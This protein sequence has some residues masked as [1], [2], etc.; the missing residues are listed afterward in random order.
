VAKILK[1]CELPNTILFG[2]IWVSPYLFRGFH[3]PHAV[4]PTDDVIDISDTR[5]YAKRVH[6]CFTFISGNIINKNHTH[7][8]S[9]RA[10]GHFIAILLSL[11]GEN[12]RSRRA[13]F[14][15]LG[16]SELLD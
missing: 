2:Y 4:H 10:A 8:C 6:I 7:F 14:R 16:L 12:S 5:T 3:Q 13:S 11:A 15:E 9:D 1:Y